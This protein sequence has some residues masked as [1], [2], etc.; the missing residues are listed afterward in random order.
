MRILIVD[1]Q[2]KILSLIKRRLESL[3]YLVDVTTDA[4]RAF[5]LAG[6]GE[7]DLLILDIKLRQKIDGIDI[8]KKARSRNK[9]CAILI[10]SVLSD[11]ETKRKCFECGADDYLIKPFN[12]E[13]LVLRTKAL[14]RRRAK[15]VMKDI[16]SLE[17]LS[18]NIVSRE[19]KRADKLVK[20]SPIETSILEI[21]LR[22]KNRVVAHPQI[23]SHVW[24][25]DEP[26]TNVLESHICSLRKKIDRNFKVKLL[27]T[28]YG[29]GYF[30]GRRTLI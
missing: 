7:Y 21:L 17:D 14:L 19:I 23:V 22:N 6:V 27:H 4:E 5:M 15:P 24:G 3:D 16:L 12:I 30:L 2:A 18:M 11:I 9:N 13:E 25:L 10:F 8:C 29:F 1:D 28:I 26:E 20:L